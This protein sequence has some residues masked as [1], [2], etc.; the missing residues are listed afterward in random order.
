MKCSFRIFLTASLLLFTGSVFVQYNEPAPRIPFVKLVNDTSPQCS[1]GIIYDDNTFELFIGL[2]WYPDRQ[3]VQKIRPPTYPYRINQMCFC[4]TRYPF[5]SQNWQFDIVVYDTTGTDGTPGN[6]LAVI[7]NQTAYDVPVYP[8]YAWYDFNGLTG[9]PDIQTGSYYMGMLYQHGGSFG[10]DTSLFTPS[11]YIY[12]KH[13]TAQWTPLTIYNSNAK[14]LGIRAD[15]FRPAPN[16][17][18]AAGPFLSLP[19][20]FEINSTYD[21]KALISNLGS[22]NETGVLIKF[23]VDGVISDFVN[24]SLNSGASDSVSFQWTALDGYHMLSIVSALYNDQYRRNDTVSVVILGGAAAGG[25]YTACRTGLH[26]KTIDNASVYDS[27]YITIPTWAFGVR[28]VNIEID[29]LMHPWISDLVLTLIHAGDSVDI[30]SHVDASGNNF[31]GTMLNDSATLSIANGSPPFTGLF[32]PSH[33]LS[34]FN[35]AITSPDGYWVL[36]I[37][38]TQ[39]AEN[40][41]LQAWC[42]T[43]SYY[44]YIGGIVA[45]KVPNYYSLEQ[46]Y[47]NPFNPSTKI[48]YTIPKGG[49]VRLAVYDI[50]GRETA[51]L[52]NEYKDPG[53][54]TIDFNASALSSGV[55]FYSIRA[56]DFTDTKK[57]LL[58]K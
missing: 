53:E 21:I 57:M 26:V 39:P 36:K 35:R 28:D 27:V 19:G 44:T 6:L 45:L 22:S 2:S 24:V 31:I 17:D 55:Y 3:M 33:P 14:A 11:W 48:K 7:P 23:F 5:G 30:I 12:D 58:I 13:D 16:H 54:Y 56:G 10:L 42:L 49:E 41:Y 25:E 8:D 1:N 46:N 4:L 34:V 9:I 32:I 18:F 40:G 20:E 37:T 15:G 52:V 29:S 47:P 51:V 43:V 50:L 38:D